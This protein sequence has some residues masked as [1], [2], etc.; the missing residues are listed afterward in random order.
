[1]NDERPTFLL[2]GEE[3]PFAPGQTVI[4][5]AFAAGRYVP[6]LCYHREFRPHGAASCAR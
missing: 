1:M 2:D 4:Q 5:A 3:V 6:H